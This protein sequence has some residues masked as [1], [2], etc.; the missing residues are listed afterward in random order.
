MSILIDDLVS[1][2]RPGNCTYR[3]V[4]TLKYIAKPCSFYGLSTLIRRIKDAYRILIGKSCAYHYWEDE[5]N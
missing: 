2:F 1:V 5:N 4:G 3:R